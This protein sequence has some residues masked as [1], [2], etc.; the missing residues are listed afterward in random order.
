MDRLDVS[1]R[2]IE[3][4]WWKTLDRRGTPIVLLHE[5]LGAVGSRDNNHPRLWPLA[6][7]RGAGSG[8]R[9]DRRAVAE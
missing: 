9:R 4:Q 1:G 3:G 6:A 7:P 8:A 2:G 5:G